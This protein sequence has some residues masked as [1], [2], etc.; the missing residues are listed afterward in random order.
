MTSG[1]PGEWFGKRKP[2]RA[3]C[4]AIVGSWGVLAGGAVVHGFMPGI[5]AAESISARTSFIAVGSIA[6][7]PW[8]GI[9][10]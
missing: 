7:T 8:N 3:S 4:R 2:D 6:E 1:A 10:S 9:P 5:P